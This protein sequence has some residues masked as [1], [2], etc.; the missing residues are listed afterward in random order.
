MFA[1][2]MGTAEGQQL[3][4]T[5]DLERHGSTGRAGRSKAGE[6]LTSR[7]CIDGLLCCQ[8]LNQARYLRGVSHGSI[9]L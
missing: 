5:R 8:S 3:G 9:A 7:L 4:R 1:R 2:L 6:R